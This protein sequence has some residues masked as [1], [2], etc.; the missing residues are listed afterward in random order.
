MKNSICYCIDYVLNQRQNTKFQE[1]SNYKVVLL[2]GLKV[3]HTFEITGDDFNH[4]F[5]YVAV[6]FLSSL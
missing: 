1:T 6:V 2:T 4:S 3:I 5:Y